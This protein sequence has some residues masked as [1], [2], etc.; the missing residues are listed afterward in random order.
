[1]DGRNKLDL[2]VRP[3]GGIC[4]CVC[5]ISRW[6][7][8][9]RQ[10]SWTSGLNGN[11]SDVIRSMAGTPTT[12]NV[13]SFMKTTVKFADFKSIHVISQIPTAKLSQPTVEGKPLTRKTSFVKCF[14]VTW[15][16]DAN[17]DIL[18]RLLE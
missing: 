3:D 15:A 7:C 18:V 10:V 16:I 12:F 14:H 9:G 13:Y 8:A 1:M 2:R 4:G 5:W 17:L 6:V 11:N